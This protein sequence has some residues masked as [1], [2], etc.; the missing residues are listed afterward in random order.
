MTT[1]TTRA[2]AR[3]AGAL[4][5]GF[6]AALATAPP[7]RADGTTPA[8][9]DISTPKP[10]TR[11]RNDCG[12]RFETAKRA[13]TAKA[14]RFRH[15]DVTVDEDGVYLSFSDDT[16]SFHASVYTSEQPDTDGWQGDAFSDLD[17][18]PAVPEDCPPDDPQFENRRV[19]HHR[20]G[21]VRTNDAS[22]VILRLFWQTM[23][24][25]VDDCL[26]HAS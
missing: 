20:L 11:W 18:E 15:A 14:P 19:L 22:P 5:L 26:E 25:A 7:A 12:A 24:R 10:S 6:A 23:R 17:L 1:T 2:L 13:L 16:D 8:R 21:R 3:R 4:A 9:V